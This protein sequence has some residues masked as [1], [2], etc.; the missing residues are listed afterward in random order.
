MSTR[1]TRVTVTR[2]PTLPRRLA[3]AVAALAALA[4]ASGALAGDGPAQPHGWI[5]IGRV[6]S[7]T[8]D[9]FFEHEIG[10]GNVAGLAAKW[11]ATTTGDVSGTPAV[12]NGAVYFGD[13]GGTVWKLDAETGAVIWSHKVPDY[14]GIAG[15][16]ARTSPSLDGDVLVVGVIRPSLTSGPNML[17]IDANTGALRWATQ[18]HPDR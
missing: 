5:T 16:Y 6:P 4:V 18:I 1:A 2:R 11:A 14:T 9:Q 12:A 8:R 17:G 3:L 15:D 13:F 10:P 7:N